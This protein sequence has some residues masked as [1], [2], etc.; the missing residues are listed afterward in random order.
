[1]LVLT[2]DGSQRLKTEF[3][4]YNLTIPAKIEYIIDKQKYGEDISFEKK[5]GKYNRVFKLKNYEVYCLFDFYCKF[6]LWL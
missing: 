6:I 5:D 3:N 4:K 1:M 2:Y